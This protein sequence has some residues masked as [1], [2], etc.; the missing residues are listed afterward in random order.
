MGHLGTC[1]SRWHLRD[2]FRLWLCC[3]MAANP[4]SLV[5]AWVGGGLLQG[6]GDTLRCSHRGGAGRQGRQPR[7]AG[8]FL[9]PVSAPPPAG[10]FLVRGKASNEGPTDAAELAVSAW[11]P[12]RAA[13]RASLLPISTQ[14]LHQSALL[15]P[16]AEAR[17]T[18]LRTVGGGQGSLARA[19]P[20]TLPFWGGGGCAVQAPHHHHQPPH[21]LTPSPISQLRA[22]AITPGDPGLERSKGERNGNPL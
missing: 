18:A 1:C 4:E 11:E 15:L 8:G 17:G 3:C 5:E 20:C 13:G 2:I 14:V 6:Q 16:G 12:R 10:C 19:G 21:S 22:D 9:A 7:R